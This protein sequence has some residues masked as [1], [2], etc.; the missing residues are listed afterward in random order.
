MYTQ[1]KAQTLM[2]LS[3]ITA[4]PVSDYLVNGQTIARTEFI[5]QLRKTVEWCDVMLEKEALPVEVISA[6]R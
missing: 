1:I 3:E 6:A 4:S 2:L 5:E